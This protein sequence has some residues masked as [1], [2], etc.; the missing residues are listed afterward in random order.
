VRAF[1]AGVVVPPRQLPSFEARQTGVPTRHVR[2]DLALVASRRSCSAA[3]TLE[4]PAGG[5]SGPHTRPCPANRVPEEKRARRN[6][7][8][9]ASRA[10]ATPP[11]G[12]G[13]DAHFTSSLL[14]FCSAA[15]WE[16]AIAQ[17]GA[18]A[19]GGRRTTQIADGLRTCREHASESCGPRA[20]GEH[21][22]TR[23]WTRKQRGGSAW[24]R[25]L[26]VGNDALFSSVRRS[27]T[28]STRR[29]TRSV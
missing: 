1:W 7:S 3:C 8:G 5:R 13:K 17:K 19:P 14:W 28:G 2:R 25:L 29:A 27:K 21:T 12:A 20:C 24:G 6:C 23:A 16:V 9:A 18:A 26:L 11:G 15:L 22:A 4:Q 10:R